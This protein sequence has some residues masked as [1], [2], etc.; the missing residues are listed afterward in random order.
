MDQCSIPKCRMLL[1]NPKGP[2]FVAFLR[3]RR[4][5]VQQFVHQF[6]ANV[7]A[8]PRRYISKNFT[9]MAGPWIFV[10]FVSD[11]LECVSYQGLHGTFA[12]CSSDP[13]N[14]T[15]S[16]QWTNMMFYEVSRWLSFLCAIL[17]KRAGEITSPGIRLWIYIGICPTWMEPVFDFP[18]WCVWKNIFAQICDHLLPT[19]GCVNLL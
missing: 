19:R 16:V 1:P 14:M 9:H 17:W 15:P 5:K 8:F 10:G 13:I 3:G 6:G 7:P 18:S 2:N 4:F 12:S 11:S